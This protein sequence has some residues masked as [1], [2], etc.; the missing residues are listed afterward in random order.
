VILLEYRKR[1]FM[2]K[3]L[4]NEPGFTLMELIIVVVAVIIVAVILFSIY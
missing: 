4:R 3:I 2:G 1:G